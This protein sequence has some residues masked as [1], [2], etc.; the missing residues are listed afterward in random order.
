MK[1]I[2]VG[3]VAATALTA[4][5]IPSIASASG[6]DREFQGPN[7]LADC[8]TAAT[9]YNQ[10]NDPNRLPIVCQHNVGQVDAEGHD[11]WHLSLGPSLNLDPAPALG[12][13][14]L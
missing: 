3:L 14:S 4:A 7:A 8:Q 5:V 12:T 13:G 9:L 11:I 2:L 10:A 6:N 1:K